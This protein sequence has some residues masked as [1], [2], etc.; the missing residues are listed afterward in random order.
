MSSLLVTLPVTASANA[1]VPGGFSRPSPQRRGPLAALR[2]P[3]YRRA[4]KQML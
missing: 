3:R 4:Q 2:L 1:A